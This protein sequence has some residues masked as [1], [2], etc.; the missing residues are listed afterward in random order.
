VRLAEQAYRRLGVLD[1]GIL[2]AVS[3]GGDSVGLLLSTL[4]LRSR[5]GLTV[6]VATVDHGARAGSAAEAAG[7]VELSRRLEV[8][9][10][11]RKVA[12]ALG[13]QFEARARRAR[14]RALESVRAER[15][16]AFIATAH[17]ADD[18]AETLL[19]R[20]A[21]GASLQGASG[22]RERH[23]R[24]IRPLLG[25][26]RPEVR[27]YV[28]AEGISPVEDPMNADPRYFRARIR[29]TALP[30]LA[31]ASGG[32]VVRPLADFARFAA[33]DSEHL[34]ALAALAWEEL[35]LGEGLLDGPRLA[36]LPAALRRR[37]LA[38]LL[39]QAG[40]PVRAASLAAAERGL[41]GVRRESLSRDAWVD[42][43]GGVVRVV[44]QAEPARPKVAEIGSEW[45]E[46]GWAGVELKRARSWD[47]PA[48]GWSA[49]APAAGPPPFQ[50]RTRRP[51]DR[52]A[53]AGHSK[54]LQ[55]LMVDLGIPREIRDQLPVVLRGD[56]KVIWLP[57][58]WSTP[59]GGDQGF[60]V[61][62]ARDGGQAPGW[63]VR[64][65]LMTGKGR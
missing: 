20:L 65:R 26:T 27:A 25:C 17:T 22:I 58:V 23:G 15:G 5:L 19:M 31:S 35:T 61:A 41:S 57:G 50:V 7:V 62:R 13:P 44:S 54:K 46:A 51:G 60:L 39:D 3:G 11:V 6:E 12:L 38:R 37:V 10:T 63:L 14:Y 42:A 49:S 47:P 29:A 33:E 34:E 53:I 24:V 56:G 36:R 48:G 40:E 59:G 4:S 28:A 43:R 16:L 32:D 21:R 64:Y 2:V 18:Q 55:D 1:Q 52:A 30:A 9:C 45:V 8:P